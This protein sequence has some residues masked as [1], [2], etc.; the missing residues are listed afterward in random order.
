[1]LYNKTRLDLMKYYKFLTTD[2][3]STHLGVKWNLPKNGKPG[4][5]MPSI[6]GRLLECENGYHFCDSSQLFDWRS[7][8]LYEL[9]VKG[10]VIKGE[11]KYI[12]RQCRLV[13]KIDAWNT[14]T[15][16]TFAADCAERI[17]PLF[18]K[19]YPNDSRPRDAILA[20]RVRTVSAHAAADAA[21]TASAGAYTDADAAADAAARAGARAGANAATARAAARAARAGAH[22][23]AAARATA[24][25]TSA[26]AHADAR[27][28][29]YAASAT[30]RAAARAA[31]AGAHA[32]AAAPAAT[33][34]PVH[35]VSDRAWRVSH[36]VKL[37]GIEE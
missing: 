10:Q 17:L 30:A 36:I 21:Y 15:L 16:I 22:A 5:W 6:E 27:A 12:G 20:A 19:V 4:K 3:R 8:S 14:D 32:D 11:G 25:A 9:E 2:G 37:L 13:R 23:D 26:G 28:A 29:A 31:R 35:A 18:E 24:Y 7:S 33:I 1:M 34:F